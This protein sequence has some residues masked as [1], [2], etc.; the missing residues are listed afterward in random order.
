MAPVGQCSV[1]AQARKPSG[2]RAMKSP[3]LIQVTL[4]SGRLSNRRQGEKCV[5]VRP[6]SRAVLS[7]AAVTSPPSVWAMSWQP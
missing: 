3:W 7:C 4:C 1:T 6:Y 2:R 5:S